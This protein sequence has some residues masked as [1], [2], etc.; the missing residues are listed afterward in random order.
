M[1]TK[2]TP[3]PWVVHRDER[4][5]GYEINSVKEGERYAREICR[6][7]F[8]RQGASRGVAVRYFE[9]PEDAANIDLLVAAPELAKALAALVD[10][11]FCG[12]F[13]ACVTPPHRGPLAS[14]SDS[15]DASKSEVWA[16]WDAALDALRK[17]GFK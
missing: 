8:R 2:P 10:R 6:I 7:N 12:H 4:G 15:E 5:R 3:G 17:A 16:E 9:H 11:Y 14:A 1:N 13:I